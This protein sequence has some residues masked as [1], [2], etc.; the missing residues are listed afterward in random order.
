MNFIEV[1]KEMALS[2]GFAA[3]TL[4]QGIMLAVSFVLFYFAIVKKFEPLLLVPIAF[5]IMLANLPLAG[6]MADPAGIMD[7]AQK[8]EGAH[9]YDDGELRLIYAG[10][11]TSIFQ[12][13][14]FMGVCAMTDFGPLHA[15]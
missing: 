5:G 9:W 4:E 7:A 11:K 6:L 13:L 3:M 14:I 10:V 2:S 15:N 8:I 12:S 1:L